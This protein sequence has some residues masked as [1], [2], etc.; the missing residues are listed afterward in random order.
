M[1][2]EVRLQARPAGRDEIPRLTEPLKPVS[3]ATVMVELAVVPAL[4]VRLVGP[5][6]T[7]KS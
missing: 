3:G 7:E 4:T 1:L 2:D 6:V 5:A